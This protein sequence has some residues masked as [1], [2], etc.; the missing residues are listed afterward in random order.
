[1]GFH[2]L[3]L[4]N[5]PCLRR[6][7]QCAHPSQ[8][9]YSKMCPPVTGKHTAICLNCLCALYCFFLSL[10]PSPFLSLSA[11]LAHSAY[12]VS[13]RSGSPSMVA[14][15]TSRAWSGIDSYTGTGMSTERSSVF[16]WA[17]DV[18]HAHT[19][20]HT[21]IYLYLSIHTQPLYRWMNRS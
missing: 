7:R 3:T 14:V 5:T 21:H 15:G 4:I 11:S 9:Y 16:S 10:S 20:K 18:R 2:T 6:Q 17:Y 12:F 8:G 1:M 19:N 13:V